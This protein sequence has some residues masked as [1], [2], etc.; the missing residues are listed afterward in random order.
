[1][2]QSD[3]RKL[4]EEM[5]EEDMFDDTPD[6]PAKQIIICDRLLKRAVNGNF[7][8]M[9]SGLLDNIKKQIESLEESANFIYCTER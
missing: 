8:Y 2:T 4:E 9:A 1:M 7:Y 3:I 6:T 5:I